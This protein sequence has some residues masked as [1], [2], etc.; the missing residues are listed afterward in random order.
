MPT[1]DEESFNTLVNPT[2]FLKGDI[3]GITVAAWTQ[4]TQVNQG[5]DLN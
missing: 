5:Q 2:G 1:G 4:S 3:M